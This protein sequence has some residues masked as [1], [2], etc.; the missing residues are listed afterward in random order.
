MKYEENKMSPSSLTSREMAFEE[1]ILEHQC[2]EEITVFY[3]LDVNASLLLQSDGD[4]HSRTKD[5][6][7]NVNEKQQKTKLNSSFKNIP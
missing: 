4:Q 5:I 3:T 1:R 7:R 2:K 6:V